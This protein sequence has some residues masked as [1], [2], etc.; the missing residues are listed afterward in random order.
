MGLLGTLSLSL[1]SYL[2]LCVSLSLSSLM[3][4]SFQWCIIC[5]VWHDSGMIWRLEI[6]NIEVIT[7][8][9]RDR[10]S[11]CRLD[12]FHVFHLSS[13]FLNRCRGTIFNL[14]KSSLSCNWC[15]CWCCGFACL[16]NLGIWKD[17]LPYLHIS[18]YL[19]CMYHSS[20]TLPNAL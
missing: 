4:S 15:W 10:I 20:F 13:Q 14:Q 16:D 3:P 19:Q 11:I 18:T 12:P 5:G 6:G 8:G 2:S 17:S 7:Y 1:S 9:Q